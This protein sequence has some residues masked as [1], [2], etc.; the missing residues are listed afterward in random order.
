MIKGFITFS[1]LIIWILYFSYSY[2][3]EDWKGIIDNIFQESINKNFKPIDDRAEEYLVNLNESKNYCFGPE[4]QMDFTECVDYIDKIFSINS[5][6]FVMWEEGYAKACEKSLLETI[7]K[8]EE[9]S[10][11]S[12]DAATIL[13]KYW[14]WQKCSVLYEFK[15]SIYRSVAYDILKKNKYSTLR[16]EHKKYTQENRKKYDHLLDLIRVNIWYIERLWKKWPS[17]TKK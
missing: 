5:D 2:S 10:I 1:A 8:T 16:N 14:N 3:I 13:D 11:A 12:V 7:Y 15:L 6:E 4:K 9:K 17:K